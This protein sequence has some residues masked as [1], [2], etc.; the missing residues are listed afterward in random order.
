MRFTQNFAIPCLLFAPSRGSISGQSFDPAAA[1]LLHRRALRL[2]LGLFG[3][4]LFFTAPGKTAS[5]SGFAACF[6]TRCC[7]A[8]RSPSAPMASTRWRPISPSSRSTR[9]SATVGITVMEMVRARGESLG[10][11]RAQG[12]ARD[13]PQCADDRDRAWL[14][15]QPVRP[16]L[17]R[18]VWDA[19]DLMVRAALPARFSG[20]AACWSAIGPRAICAAKGMKRRGLR[21]C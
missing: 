7:S 13:V 19:V 9:R 12:A 5:P 11:C 10:W 6:P 14:R 1:V 2:L 21:D 16:A 18:R 8:C 20:S 17:P 15:G 4:R 3:A